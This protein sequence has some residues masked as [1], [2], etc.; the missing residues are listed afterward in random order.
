MNGQFQHFKTL[1]S[2]LFES[3]RYFAFF[4]YRDP[5]INMI[6]K[7]IFVMSILMVTVLDK[8]THS[9]PPPYPP[10]SFDKILLDAP[11]S[12]LGQRPCLGNPITEKQLSSIPPVQRKLLST[13]VKLLKPGGTLVYST[14][15]FVS[16]ENEEQIAWLLNHFPEM[17]LE[18]QVNSFYRS[19]D[20][21]VI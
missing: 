6:T 15:T 21:P 12:A 7:R 11:C 9:H 18:S 3:L 13:A 14:C 8:P 19:N 4:Y 20:A 1:R 16:E 17:C 2:A 10:S 5:P